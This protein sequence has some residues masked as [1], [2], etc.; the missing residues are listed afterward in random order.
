LIAKRCGFRW[1][2]PIVEK[3]EPTYTVPKERG[4]VVTAEDVDVDK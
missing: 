3:K 4:M 1:G 2:W